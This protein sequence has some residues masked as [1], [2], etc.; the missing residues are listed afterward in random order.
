MLQDISLKWKCLLKEKE[1]KWES[2]LWIWWNLMTT[3][4]RQHFNVVVTKNSRF[5]P[6]REKMIEFPD[7]LKN[8]LNYDSE[9]DFIKIGEQIRALCQN[10]PRMNSHRYQTLS[11]EDFPVSQQ[12]ERHVHSTAVIHNN[13]HHEKWKLKSVS[14]SQS[15]Q[16]FNPIYLNNMNTIWNLKKWKNTNTNTTIWSSLFE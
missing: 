2:R 13:S 14:L 5:F 9:R 4:R 10:E 16:L 6:V 15:I 11:P 7:I 8:K 3:L 1:K 12:C